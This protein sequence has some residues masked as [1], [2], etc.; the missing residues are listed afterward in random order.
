[1]NDNIQQHNIQKPQYWST[2]LNS[3]ELKVGL[4]SIILILLYMGLHFRYGYVMKVL[5]SWF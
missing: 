2:K 1:M 4:G 5:F 3:I